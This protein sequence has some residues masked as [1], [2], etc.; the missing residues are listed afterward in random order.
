MSTALVEP[1]QLPYTSPD[2]SMRTQ[3][4]LDVA[5]RIGSFQGKTLWVG[6]YRMRGTQKDVIAGLIREAGRDQAAQWCFTIRDGIGYVTRVAHDTK[7]VPGNL[8]QVSGGS[9][10]CK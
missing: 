3:T 8:H 10:V 4:N 2:Q 6:G 7:V 5:N 9:P 1:H